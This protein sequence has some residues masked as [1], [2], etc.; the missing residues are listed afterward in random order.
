MRIVSCCSGDGVRSDAEGNIRRRPVVAGDSGGDAV[1]GDRSDAGDAVGCGSGDGDGRGAGRAAVR[2]GRDRD[3]G[4]A[5]VLRAGDD[6]AIS[7]SRHAV[8]RC[9]AEPIW[10]AAG[11]SGKGR[12]GGGHCL[13]AY[14][15]SEVHIARGLGGVAGGAG[16]GGPRDGVARA[17]RVSW[18]GRQHGCADDDA[19]RACGCIDGVGHVRCLIRVH[20]AHDEIVAASIS[21]RDVGDGE[22]GVVG[23][24]RRDGCGAVASI[25]RGG[26]RSE[27]RGASDGGTARG[28]AVGEVYTI[29]APVDQRHVLRVG[30]EWHVELNGAAL[31]RGVRDERGADVR[32][33]DGRRDGD[34]RLHRGG[35]GIELRNLRRVQTGL[36]DRQEVVRGFRRIV[37]DVEELIGREANIKR[38]RIWIRRVRVGDVRRIAHHEVRGIC[39]GD[40][41]GAAFKA[42]AIDRSACDESIGAITGDGG[43]ADGRDAV[44]Q[45]NGARV[46]AVDVFKDF[47]LAA[48]RIGVSV[49]GH[50]R[51]GERDERRDVGCGRVLRAVGIRLEARLCAVG[52]R[53]GDALQRR[54]HIE[55][56][57][58]LRVLRR[59]ACCGANGWEDVAHP[60]EHVADHSRRES[61]A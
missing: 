61:D 20:V 12:A 47:G 35:D 5:R 7:R 43:A 29:L 24:S 60:E 19:E 11:E 13:R 53:A 52:I 23:A 56:I 45:D 4:I 32:R 21:R 22:E 3:H 34:G 37:L 40:D 18:L 16:D 41:G 6:V 42:D 1:H 28:G 48:D 49:V 44:G 27:D 2:G 10:R 51:A 38:E 58:G 36:I 15:V 31:I 33:I 50:V 54:P 39:D 59:D 55:S 46:R 9:R 17:R 14:D 26:V 57:E 25:W 8:G 30:R